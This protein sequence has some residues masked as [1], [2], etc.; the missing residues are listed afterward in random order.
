MLVDLNDLK[1]SLRRDKRSGVFDGDADIV[2]PKVDTKF[3]GERIDGIKILK[4]LERIIRV[5]YKSED[6]INDTSYEKILNIILSNGHESTLEHVSI[7]ALV[8]TNRGVSHEWVR[9]R[10]AAYTQESTRYVNYLKKAGSIVY[11]AWI[12]DKSD[13]FKREWYMQ[14]WGCLQTYCDWVDKEGEYG[15]TPQEARDILPN[16]LK[17]EFVVTMNIRSLR[18]FFGL[19]LPKTA[20]PDMRVVS[21]EYFKQLQSKIPMLFDKFLEIIPG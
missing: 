5:A 20:H 21:N 8:T 7:T 1:E 14:Q 13:K 10:I 18:N 19:R 16:G 3:L 2:L 11:P 17:T 9:H 12:N 4:K 6:N 15:L